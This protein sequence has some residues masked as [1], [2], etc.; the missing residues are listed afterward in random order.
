MMVYAAAPAPLLQITW[1]FI[2]IEIIRLASDR[3]ADADAV[4]LAQTH[5]FFFALFPL[6]SISGYNLKPALITNTNIY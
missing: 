4:A 3:W 1:S 2:F 5:F 6:P